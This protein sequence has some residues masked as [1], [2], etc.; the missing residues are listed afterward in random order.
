MTPAI[1]PKHVKQSSIS[2]GHAGSA[3]PSTVN[4]WRGGSTSHLWRGGAISTT[5]AKISI[6]AMN[7]QTLNHKVADV[8]DFFRNNHLDILVLQETGLTTEAFSAI[9]RMARKKNLRF[10]AVA[11]RFQSN[12]RPFEGMAILSGWPC[13]PIRLQCYK[14]PEIALRV[15]A[16]QVH[17]ERSRPFVLVNLHLQSGDKRIA[18]LRDL[19]VY[20][21]QNEVPRDG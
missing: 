12:G 1:D 6:A 21:S 11:P 15:Q 7:V 9:D 19:Q 8:F 18:T 14:D 17:K 5:D 20:N 16:I 4:C 2:N 3:W 10:H 13:R